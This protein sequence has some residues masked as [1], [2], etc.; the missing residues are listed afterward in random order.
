MIDVGDKVVVTDVPEG[1]GLE[2]IEV[3]SMGEVVKRVDETCVDILFEVGK[4]FLGF[5][6]EEEYLKSKNY[7]HT[8]VFL[9]EKFDNKEEK[10]LC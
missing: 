4:Q 9:V 6:D 1:C 2:G 5:D 7:G 8:H 10:K 3:G